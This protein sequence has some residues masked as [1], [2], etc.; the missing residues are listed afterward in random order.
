MTH[1]GASGTETSLTSSKKDNREN[2]VVKEHEIIQ[3]SQ[4]SDQHTDTIRSIQYITVTD[5][6]LVLT[7]SLDKYVKIFTVDGTCKGILKQGYMVQPNGYY[8]DF[9]I[10]NYENAY[11]KRQD[12]VKEMLDA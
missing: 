5:E 1:E 4:W 2:S 8:W 7:A 12:Q 6:P 3:I 9:L 10:E 11:L